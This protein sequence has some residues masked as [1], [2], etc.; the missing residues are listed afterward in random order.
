MDAAIHRTKQPQHQSTPQDKDLKRLD[1]LGCKLYTSSALQFKLQIIP[2]S[3]QAMTRTTTTSSLILPPISRRTGERT[4]KSV[5]VEGQLVSLDMADPA[6]RT[7]ATAVVMRRSS[8]LSA[9]GIPKDLQTTKKLKRPSPSHYE[10]HP[11]HT[12]DIL[13]PPQETTVSTLSEALHTTIS[14][15]PAQT[16]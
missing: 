9:S 3:L 8:W 5:P 15:A 12:R 10:R 1:L 6:A 7:T 13:V 14:P 11:A 16:I 2:P 4:F